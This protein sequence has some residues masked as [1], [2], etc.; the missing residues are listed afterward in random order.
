VNYNNL[1]TYVKN[2]NVFR[3]LIK[4]AGILL[5]GDFIASIISLV[6]MALT[7]RVLGP[8]GFGIIALI[9]AYITI[10]DRL[11]NF[12]SWQAIIKYGSDALANNEEDSIKGLIKFGLVLDITTALLGAIIAAG[13]VQIVGPYMGWGYET[14]NYAIVYSFVIL[15]NIEGT[16]TAILRLYDQFSQFS[17]VRVIQ[18]VYKFLGV[19]IAFYFSAG[20]FEFV[21][22]WISAQLLG[23]L[24][25]LLFAYFELVKR[26][27]TGFYYASIK[28]ILKKYDE[29]WGYV[30]TTN[31]HGTVRMASLRLDTLI[32]GSVLGNAAAGY[33]KVAKQF[34]GI[35]SKF[36]GPLYKSIYPE[37]TKLWSNKE[38]ADFKRLILISGLLAGFGA[39]LIWVSFLI[40]GKYIL[41]LTVGKSYIESYSV[42]IL[43]MFAIN[44]S[45]FTFPLTPGMLA[46]GYPRYSFYAILGST[47]FYFAIL[48]PCL[49]QFGVKGVGIG[50]I[51]F[52]IV[53]SFIMLFILV[54][55]FKLIK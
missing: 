21:V 12:Q 42:L 27:L 13:A 25:L 28:S 36:T 47:L 39:I 44:L 37:L 35:L 49:L 14:I 10:V 24:L 33:L 3:R 32:V 2:N 40:F 1:F 16:P 52:Y 15:F 38:Y 45:I 4:N 17:Y 46:M 18:A 8:E 5:S 54:R 50:Y 11:V 6:S 53:W 43:Y 19:V 30:W 34:A 26:G 20:L 51:V 41:I 7:A 22:I 9:Q 31:L 29:M 48:Y 23:Y 55:K